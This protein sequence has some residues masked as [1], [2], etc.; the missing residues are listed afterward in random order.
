MSAALLQQSSL[1]VEKRIRL[2]LLQRSNLFIIKESPILIV[3]TALYN[4]NYY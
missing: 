4:I 2:L 3:P 1:F